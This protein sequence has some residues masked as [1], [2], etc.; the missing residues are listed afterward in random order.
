MA[1]G[2]HHWRLGGVLSFVLRRSLEESPEFERMKSL[3]PRQPFR[4]LLLLVE[5]R[6][7]V[8]LG[9]GSGKRGIRSSGGSPVVSCH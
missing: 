7:D 9:Y 2:L 5:L 1:H 4:E 8:S 3:A 6:M